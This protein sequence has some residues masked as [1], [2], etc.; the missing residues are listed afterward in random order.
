MTQLS[1]SLANF[2]S[3]IAW[4]EGTSTSSITKDN[5]Y[6]I[7]VSGIHGPNRF[8]DYSDHPFAPQFNRAPVVCNHATPPLLS[9]ASGRYQLMREWW[10][11]RPGHPGYKA[12]LNLPDFGH[13]SQDAVAV[14][15]I[16]E[17][18]ALHLIAAGE[19]QAAITAC[20]NIWAS[21]PGNGY[22]QH[23]GKTMVELLEYFNG[24]Q[25]AQ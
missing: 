25:G 14:Q 16:S 22:G 23:G 21:F 9:D 15:Q 18:N 12:M 4:S 3:L 19:I 8:D 2:L 24:L 1:P 10:I 11:G 13:K 17:H 5:G 7:I 6:D 20:S